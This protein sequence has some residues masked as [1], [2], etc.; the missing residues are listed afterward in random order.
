MASV[1]LKDGENALIVPV[2]KDQCIALSNIESGQIVQLIFFGMQDDQIQFQG[3]KL[4]HHLI[5][6]KS[7]KLLFAKSLASY[8]IDAEKKALWAALKN[9]YLKDPPSI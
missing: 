7:L 8:S 9:M 6:L 5:E 3:E 2:L 1:H 4:M